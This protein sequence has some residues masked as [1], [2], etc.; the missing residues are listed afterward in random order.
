M[1]SSKFIDY[2]HRELKLQEPDHTAPTVIDLFAGCGGLAL[3]FEVAGFKTFGF[4]VATDA[5]A[6]YGENLH[7]ECYCVRLTEETGKPRLCCGSSNFTSRSL[8]GAARLH[9]QFVQN[10][11]SERVQVDEIWSFCYAKK[12]TVAAGGPLGS[13]EAG[14]VW[15]WTGLDPETKLLIAWHVGDRTMNSGKVFMA[16]LRS[17]LAHEVHLTSD[18]YGVYAEA[19]EDAFGADVDH[20]QITKRQ[21]GKATTSHVE[22]HNLTLR[23]G[24]RRYTRKTNAF[25]K[26]L[27][28]HKRSVA[29]FMFYYN[30]IRIHKSLRMTPAMAAGLTNTLH[31]LEWLAEQI[32][33][34]QPKPKRPKT[35]KPRRK[36]D[37]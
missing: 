25:S 15:T 31:D 32:E 4:E 24:M 30:F 35:Y 6:T 3:G 2:L 7:G 10:V 17:R 9:D 27:E 33:A 23:M 1:D 13:T 21:T 28:P 20:H 12:R 14:D 5:C 8:R 22:R 37:D 16:D 18:Q 11:Q 36:Q 19:V 26:K 29:L 34:A